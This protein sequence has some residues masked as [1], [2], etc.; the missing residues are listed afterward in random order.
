MQNKILIIAGMHR[1]GT[2]LTTQWLYRCG[3]NVG[4]NLL[5]AGIGNDD[6]HY[7]DIDFYEAQKQILRNKN[8]EDSGFT[9]T[10]V[11]ALMIEEK[12]FLKNIISK[13]NQAAGEWGWKDPRTCLFLR[14]YEDLLPEAYYLIV[15]RDWKSTVSSLI[16]R[17]YKIIYPTDDIVIKGLFKGY[18]KKLEVKRRIEELCK[19]KATNFLKI[20][21][22]Y[23]KEI[24]KSMSR[25]SKDNYAV[26]N[27]GALLESDKNVFHKLTDHWNFGLQYISFKEIY[28]PKLISKEINT[29]QFI[30][31]VLIAEAEKIETIL[32]KKTTF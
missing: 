6:G 20:W 23:N 24:L 21:I 26:V 7:E 31:K 25:L 27:F 15:F 22:L 3:L 13:K 28:K 29:T 8:I 11:P 19:E 9:E 4:E 2:S 18:R 17:T 10:P 32:H 16:S 30:D 5:G 14:D 12:E 1:S